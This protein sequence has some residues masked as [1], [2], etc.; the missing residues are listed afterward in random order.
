MGAY[1]KE[2]RDPQTTRLLSSLL[3]TTVVFAQTTYVWTNQN[4]AHLTTGDLNQGFCNKNKR[5]GS[6]SGQ[7]CWIAGDMILQSCR[8]LLCLL[9]LVAGVAG[10]AELVLANFSSTNLLKVMAVG[11]SITDDCSING[12]WRAPLQPLLETNSFPFAFTGRQAST[13]ATGFSKVRHEGYCGAVIAPPGVFPAHQYADINNYLQKIV[14]DALAIQTNKP[15]VMLVLIGANDIGRG[16]DPYQVAT[17]H[18]SGLLDII[19]SNTPSVQV[20]L[21]KTTSLQNAGLGYSTYAAN[22]MIYNATLQKLVNQRRALG[23]NVFLAD[24]FSAVDFST[25]FLPD[26]VHPNALG[27]QAMAK[28]W[29]ARL[30]SITVRTDLVTKVLINGGSSWK[31]NDTGQDLGTDWTLTN[32]DDSGWSN[33]IAR[34]GYGDPA[35][36]TTVRYGPLSANKFVTTYFRQSLVVPWNLVLTNLNLRVARADGVVVWLNGQEIYRTNLPPGP[37]GYTNL[38]LTTMTIFNRHNFY[39]TN[40]PVI[41]PTGTN[42]LAAEVH[43]GAVDSTSMGFDMEAIGT[44]YPLRP[45]SLSIGWTGVNQVVLRW[46]LAYGNSFSLYWTTN[47]GA[48]GSW[49]PEAARVQTNDSQLTVT[50]SLDSRAKFFR[51]Q[52]Q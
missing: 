19:F 8:Y 36:A 12:A 50:Q 30:Q 43:L 7:L 27:L 39:P 22:V 47:L 10:R 26:H 38:A 23:Q 48:V 44:G 20:G 14:P 34:L 15:D 16:R 3:V 52:Q 5:I 29:L 49:A 28:E 32:Y 24:M 42:W 9:L 41:L 18:M 33:G 25:M 2:A 45:P 4:P 6:H 1:E 37:I 21:A 17:N 35:T 13:P 11:D 51:L 31:Y 40:V 46:P